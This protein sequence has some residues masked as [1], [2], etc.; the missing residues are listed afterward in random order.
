M[1]NAARAARVARRGR[2]SLLFTLLA[3]LNEGIDPRRFIDAGWLGG[4]EG[5]APCSNNNDKAD[6]GTR[7]I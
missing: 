6:Y 5:G 2:R 7:T 3:A 1:A 4:F